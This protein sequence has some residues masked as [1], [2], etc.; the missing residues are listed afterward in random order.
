MPY[1]LVRM[2]N[3]YNPQ[4]RLSTH[5]SRLTCRTFTSGVAAR[6]SLQLADRL[7]SFQHSLRDRPVVQVDGRVVGASGLTVEIAGIARH[8]SLGDRIRLIGRGQ[9]EVPAEIVSFQNGLARAMPFTDLQGIGP[10]CVAR[11]H[12]P[13]THQA[14]VLHVGNAWLGRIIDPL[15]R[16]FD[17]KGPLPRGSARNVR[18]SP[19][20]AT[21]RSRLGEPLELGV[22]ALDLFSTMRR[23]QRLGIFAGSGVG[24][25]SLLSMLA[26]GADCDVAGHRAGGRAWARGQRIRRRRSGAGRARAIGRHC[27]DIGHAA[28][29]APR[30]GLR[31]HDDRGVVPR[32]GQDGPPDEWIA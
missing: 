23:G 1:L 2:R 29:D 14:G 22:R 8:V 24:K 27:R 21:K 15:G 3:V 19:P 26:R 28:A 25:S 17:G 12:R 7:L 9:S 31:C 20:D 10:G 30:G 5:F 4:A 6:M 18:A 32:S 16:P 11:V 13:G